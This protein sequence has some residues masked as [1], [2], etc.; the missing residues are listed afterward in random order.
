VDGGRFVVGAPGG[1]AAPVRA[2]LS[3]DLES[4]VAAGT[5]RLDAMIDA[6]ADGQLMRVARVELDEVNQE[7]YLRTAPERIRRMIVRLRS[8]QSPREIMLSSGA[9]PTELE[10]VLIDLIK[11]GA[12]VAVHA[13]PAEGPPPPPPSS[14]E[15]RWAKLR[16][17]AAGP[18]EPAPG[19]KVVAVTKPG[20]TAPREVDV[21]ALPVGEVRALREVAEEE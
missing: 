8:T 5:K 4:L 7:A 13:P 18:A 12:I 10:T 2:N 1:G 16:A 20:S 3:G 9:S 17:P 14:D 19:K 21:A 6:V 11:R 15:K